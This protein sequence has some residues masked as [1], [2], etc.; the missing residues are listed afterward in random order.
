MPLRDTSI[1]LIQFVPSD[2]IYKSL[3]ISFKPLPP[4]RLSACGSLCTISLYFLPDSP[5]TFKGLE[6]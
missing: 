4:N 5:M 3:A 1:E 6:R 2:R